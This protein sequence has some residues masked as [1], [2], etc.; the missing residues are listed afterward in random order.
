MNEDDNDKEISLIQ[1]HYLKRELL[2]LEIDSEA[3]ALKDFK[4]IGGLGHPF[5]SK[6][7]QDEQRFPVLQFVFRTCVQT[8]PFISNVDERMFWQE[9]IQPFLEDF[10]DKEISTSADRLESTKRR[11]MAN[12]F[13][14]LILLYTASGIQTVRGEKDAK[15]ARASVAGVQKMDSE[16]IE[17]TLPTD[18]KFING[19]EVNVAGVRKVSVR[20]GFFY[21][22]H[23]EYLVQSRMDAE[24]APL[25]TVARRYQD[26][27]TLSKNL[28]KEFPGKDLPR[29]PIRHKANTFTNFGSD[30]GDPADNGDGE[31]DDADDDVDDEELEDDGKDD[32]SL[33]E[34]KSRSRKLGIF[35]SKKETNQ[36]LGKL[37]REKQ[38][39]TLRAYLRDLLSIPQ[40][41]RSKTFLEF[42][43][44]NRVKQ[45]TPLEITDIGL[46]RRMDLIRLEQQV[47]FF[48][49][50]TERAKQLEGHLAEFKAQILQKDGLKKLFDEI[51]TKESITDLS[52][53]FQKF[54][55]WMVIEI[56]ATLYHMFIAED[57]SPE[58]YSQIR[59]LHRLMPYSVLKG[60]LRWTNPASMVK[61]IADLFLAQPF[62]RRSLLQNILYVVLGDDIRQQERLLREIEAK[63]DK[64]YRS[65]LL[66]LEE[67]VDAPG[68]VRESIRQHAAA[69]QVDIVYDIF[70]HME[71]FSRQD[72]QQ[73]LK[74]IVEKWYGDWEQAV[75]H[76]EQML[77]DTRGV[78]SYSQLK[79]YLKLRIRKRDKDKLQEFWSDAG[80]TQLLREL[81]TVFYAPL[82]R[83]L[84][85]SR[86]H[87]SVGG[88]EKF[89]NDMIKV[90]DRAEYRAAAS[91]PNELVESF[92]VLCQR[93]QQGAYRFIHNV[94]VNDSAGL[95]SDLIGWISQI[96]DFLRHGTDERLDMVAVVT[97]AAQ[98][99]NV[100]INAVKQEMD[101]IVKW[102]E[103]RRNWRDA[104]AKASSSESTDAVDWTQAVPNALGG[105]DFG[106]DQGDLDELQDSLQDPSH[107]EDE[108][109]SETFGSAIEEERKYRQRLEERVAKQALVPQRPSTKETQKLLPVFHKHLVDIFHAGASVP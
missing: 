83:L 102:I 62:G 75:K 88:L 109:V 33:D 68:E 108:G 27:S 3:D 9:R 86:I 44:L 36:N 8:F 95:F 69:K 25:V 50:A 84:K 65:M 104:S 55:D 6:P 12:K 52:P 66:V 16:K 73:Q 19:Y 72:R 37:P 21:E 39:I 77:R 93:H 99:F 30:E 53:P 38:R 43:F 98:E 107:E 100:D 46:R 101:A 105:S 22:D 89:L 87:E 28:R 2:R 4:E 91:D 10:A 26:F 1:E 90:V 29:L 23:M 106:L 64:Q 74:H 63:F 15:V 79:E 32:E 17:R 85:T 60:I 24:G 41:A 35:S 11:R 81:L 14:H 51:R 71:H 80:T 13:K 45:L 49:I 58:F 70:V 48:Q 40:V 18:G 47:K 5:T 78:D 42:L 57:S 34:G 96:I 76:G 82:I 97:Q 92:I 59:R 7:G 54:I 94:Y 61:G 67:Y 56:A 103:D 20:R 31:E